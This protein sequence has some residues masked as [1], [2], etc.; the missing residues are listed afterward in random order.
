MFQLLARLAPV[1]LVL[2]LTIRKMLTLTTGLL[3]LIVPLLFRVVFQYIVT[4]YTAPTFRDLDAFQ[5]VIHIM[6]NT[7]M[8]FPLRTHNTGRREHKK[9]Q[10][11]YSLVLVTVE[12]VG[13]AVVLFVIV[14]SKYP[15]LLT[16]YLG[17]FSIVLLC[18]ACLSEWVYYSCCHTYSEI[19]RYLRQE[20]TEEVELAQIPG[21]TNTDT[22]TAHSGCWQWCEMKQS[23][24]ITQCC[25][26]DCCNKSVDVEEEIVL[27]DL[28]RTKQDRNKTKPNLLGTKHS[29]QSDFATI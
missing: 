21:D 9:N 4:Y 12:V 17:A 6:A 10:I 23:C 15:D 19:G 7:V 5:Q 8:V 24:K 25:F 2:H 16:A 14:L 26:S 22:D 18:P 28:T 1:F 13:T 29:Q 3:L 27:D 20:I 11:L